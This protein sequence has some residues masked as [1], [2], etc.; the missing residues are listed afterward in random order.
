M[1]LLIL[2]VGRPLGNYVYEIF[3]YSSMAALAVLIVW[4]AGNEPT[5]WRRFVR[6]LYPAIMMTLFYRA[7]SGTMFLLFDKFYDSSLVSFEYSVLGF[8]PSLSIDRKYLST[9]LNELFSA[10]YFAYYL[11]IPLLLL[12]LYVKRK[13]ELIRRF[14]TS[15]CIAFFISYFLFFLYPIEGPRYHFAGQYLHQID[16]PFFRKLVNVAIDK[17]AV[18]GGCMP[19][20]H[21][22]VGL[23]VLAYTFKVSRK[24]GWL[25]VPVVIGLAVGTVWGRFHYATDVMAGAFIGLGA[26]ILVDR[27]Y[28]HWLGHKKLPV[29]YQSLGVE[30]VS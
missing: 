26:I 17:G 8:E 3:F 5:G 10:G 18:H 22:A 11:M 27:Q 30:H 14:L 29:A 28:D 4:Y 19:S 20:S 6:L 23:I 16:G 7:T 25:L 15:A 1:T 13:D 2:A 24:V 9:F 12:H 21:V